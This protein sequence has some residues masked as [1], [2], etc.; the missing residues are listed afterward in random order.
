MITLN[1]LPG[2]VADFHIQEMVRLMEYRM[3]HTPR[4]GVGVA[5]RWIYCPTCGNAQFRCY[6]IAYRTRICDGCHEAFY[7]VFVRRYHHLVHRVQRGL[8][9][10]IHEELFQV[11]YRPDRLVQTGM[12]ETKDYF[13]ASSI[14]NSY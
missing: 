13:E 10:A 3:A 7:R 1:D 4:S 9:P 2:G 11:C 8:L 14:N 5:L 12:I 6:P